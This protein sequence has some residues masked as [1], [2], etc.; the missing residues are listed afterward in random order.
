MNRIVKGTIFGGMAKVTVI[1]I[2]EIINEEIKM[3]GLSPLSA[4]AL[5]RTMA[6]GAYISNNLKNEESKFSISVNGG[7]ILGNIV[8]AGSGCNEIR[9][10]I[11]NETAELPL[12]E[13]GHLDVGKGVGGDGFFT[14]IKD[15]GLKEPYIGR[16]PLVSGEIAEDFAQYLFKS[17]GVENAVALG[18][19]IDKNGCIGAGGVIIEPLP[20]ADDN[21]IFMIE[22]IMKSFTNISEIISKQTAH[23]IFDFYFG[24][25]N[26]EKYPEEEIYLRCSCSDEKIEGLIKGLGEKEAYDIIKEQ[27]EIEVCCQFC[28]KKYRYGKAEVEKLWQK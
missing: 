12:K 18:V 19:R 28:N 8:V 21:M 13:N 27:G 3:H 22:D 24:H 2:T 25:L 10:Y 6:A 4:A 23:E 11:D 7:G 26:A 14:V 20:Q 17:E 9:G 1:E 15:Y 5:G 16:S